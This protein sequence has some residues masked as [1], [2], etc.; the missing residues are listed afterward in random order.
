[1]QTTVLEQRQ[2]RTDVL[3]A[4]AQEGANPELF[5]T[6]VVEMIARGTSPDRAGVR[7]LMAELSR[8]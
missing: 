4:A 2:F 8:E 5:E 3:Q 7:E 1:M 6:L